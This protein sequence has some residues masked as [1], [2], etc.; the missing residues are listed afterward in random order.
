MLDRSECVKTKKRRVYLR[1][2]VASTKLRVMAKNPHAVALGRL[3]GVKGGKVSMGNRT[4]EERSQFA[5]LGGEAGGV[6]R[7]QKLSPARRKAIA[8]AAAAARW[9]KKAP[10]K[11]SPGK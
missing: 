4:A 6:A 8:K 5:K 9:G 11:K 3:G 7:A 1:V 10:G 2:M